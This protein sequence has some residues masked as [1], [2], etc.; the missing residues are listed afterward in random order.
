MRT[1][2]LLILLLLAAIPL[3]V[4]GAPTIVNASIINASSNLTLPINYAVAPTSY[5]DLVEG[6]PD[7]AL[8]VCT[9]GSDISGYNAS[10]GYKAG[11]SSDFKLIGELGGTGQN[12]TTF[13]SS[14]GNCYRTAANWNFY[15]QAAVYPGVVYA[16]VSTDS[17][18]GT[19]DIWTEIKPQG[20]SNWLRGSYNLNNFASTLN[21]GTGDISV[22]VNG[23]IGTTATGSQE[24]YPGGTAVNKQAI[25][26]GVCTNT[27]NLD[28]W[29]CYSSNLT[30]PGVSNTLGTGTIPNENTADTRYLLVN[31]LNY[32]FCVGPDL[33]VT[34]LSITPAS[35]YQSESALLNATIQNLG[36]VNVTSSFDIS[37]LDGATPLPD[38]S[39]TGLNRSETKYATYSY[40]TTS[41]VS[42][43]HT[44]T[45]VVN[46]TGLGNCY[47][48]NDNITANFTLMKTYNLTVYING[49]PTDVFSRPGRPYNVT[50]IAEDSDGNNAANLTLKITEKNGLNLFALSQGFDS[51]GERRGVSSSSVADV[52]TN[53]S[54]IA[55][56]ALIP[57]GNKL[58]L[59]IYSD[60]N[61][62]DHIGNYS[63]FIELFNGAEKLQL[64][65]V[66][67]DSLI[68]QYNLTLENQ[69]ELDPTALEENS[70]F[71][72][73]NNRW[74]NAT[75]NFMIQVFGSVQKWT[76]LTAP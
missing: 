41:L 6:N 73:N 59:P 51:E 54:G 55:D 9:D 21:E 75:I 34:A 20:G 22:I 43:N 69:T 11:N 68:N 26:L 71:A 58:F 35:V 12:Y 13:A 14:V 70:I 50:I 52:M 44:I 56:L 64:Y 7:F 30:S 27:T 23:I 38:V 3:A 4:E 74:I 36:N 47:S 39:L 10:W 29:D 37:F 72:F 53:S 8:E 25:V 24:I 48:G 67:S 18:I 17:T 19:S 32:S 62:T 49:T 15:D 76:N 16:A 61:A 66:T 33:S 31:G 45:A 63:L 65:N 40:D 28:G 57:M 60:Q 42:G 46:V 5:L 2:P 1:W